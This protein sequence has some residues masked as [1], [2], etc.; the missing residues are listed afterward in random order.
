MPVS[1]VTFASRY[2]KPSKILTTPAPGH[3]LLV[4]DLAR[5]FKF[6]LF[7]YD[8]DFESTNTVAATKY[9][10]DI[11]AGFTKSIDMLEYLLDVPWKATI[12]CEINATAYYGLEQVRPIENI[13]DHFL[14][15]WKKIRPALKSFVDVGHNVVLW[16]KDKPLT[17]SDVDED[18]WKEEF[19]YHWG[20]GRMISRS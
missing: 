1:N 17:H 8:A 2:I 18:A 12:I 10:E 13:K 16:G 3:T 7:T 15:L 20:H 11:F 19:R 5:T 9:H 4:R 6:N 14:W